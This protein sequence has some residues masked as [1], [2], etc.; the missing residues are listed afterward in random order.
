MIERG[1]F[2]PPARAVE[3]ARYIPPSDDPAETDWESV[4]T[5]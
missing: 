3:G 1:S 4:R 2:T 5:L